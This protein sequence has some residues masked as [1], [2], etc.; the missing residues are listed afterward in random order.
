MR[1]YDLL[2]EKEKDSP[3]RTETSKDLSHKL[4]CSVDGCPCFPSM[5]SAF[6]CDE[7]REE[8]LKSA[9]VKSLQ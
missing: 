2:T 1:D 9:R 4:L 6:L 3:I 8:R 7:H 5:S